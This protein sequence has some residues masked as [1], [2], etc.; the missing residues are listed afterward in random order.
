MANSMEDAWI[1]YDTIQA[2]RTLI[3]NKSADLQHNYET[4]PEEY[5]EFLDF[6][7]FDGFTIDEDG[8]RSK[9]SGQEATDML[10]DLEKLAIGYN[11]DYDEIYELKESISGG[12]IQKAFHSVSKVSKEFAKDLRK[13]EK[14]ISKAFREL[15]EDIGFGA[16]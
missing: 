2:T 4:L 12:K 10:D 15:G 16:D 8:V 6:N 5:K 3:D 9:Y 1:E 7:E 14:T 11:E 13:D